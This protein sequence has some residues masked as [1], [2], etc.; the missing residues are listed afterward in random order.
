MQDQLRRTKQAKMNEMFE[1]YFEQMMFRQLKQHQKTLKSSPK[2]AVAKPAKDDDDDDYEEDDFEKPVKQSPGEQAISAVL[3]KTWDNK[4]KLIQNNV[5][6]EKTMRHFV[7]DTLDAIGP[8]NKFT[9]ENFRNVFKRFD[10][11][12]VIDKKKEEDY[13]KNGKKAPKGETN[14][15]NAIQNKNP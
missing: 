1:A 5:L 6:D 8:T 2:K 3:S 9:T 15:Y 13:K 10:I 11:Q 14:V 12:V 7:K 4:I